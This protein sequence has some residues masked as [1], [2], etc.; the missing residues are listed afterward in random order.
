MK[1]FT[2]NLAHTVLQCFVNGTQKFGLPSRVRGDR[3]VENVDVARF[4]IANRGLNRGSFIAGRSVHNQIIERLWAEVNRVSSAYYKD[5]FQFM[6]ESE[7]LDAHDELDLYALHYIYLPAI[8]ASLNEFVNQ[9]NHHGLRTMHSISPPGPPR[10]WRGPGAKFFKGP[11]FSENNLPPV[12]NFLGK[13]FSRTSTLQL[14]SRDFISI[15]HAKF[16]Y[17]LAKNRYLVLCAEIFN[18]QKRLGPNKKFSG[19]P[20]TS[21]SG[22]IS[23]P[24]CPPSR[25][26]C[27]PLALWYSEVIEIGVTDVNIGDITLYGIDPD[28]PV[29]D[30][31]TENMVVVPESTINL[32][33]NQVI[34]PD[35]LSDDSN[36]GIH[37][38]LTVRN[39]L[40]AQFQQQ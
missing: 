32:T 37:H 30:I 34:V 29:G 36:H 14:I 8:Q 6:E 27:S 18:T 26:P 23:P 3:G 11:L 15:F 7:I 19:V 24:P 33:E 22:A 4:M 9:W 28:G 10:G 12:D 39:Y 2:N 35:H 13:K 38:Y 16:R 17:L 25:R 5:L 31:E 21:G 20:S 40:K 1:C